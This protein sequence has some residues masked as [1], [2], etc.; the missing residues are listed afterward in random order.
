[1]HKRKSS[2][3]YLIR[4]Y[5]SVGLI[6]DNPT[7]VGV[8]S[9]RLADSKFQIDIALNKKNQVNNFHFIF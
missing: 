9:L 8:I 5:Y 4:F 1:M 3:S 6:M 7:L 2:K